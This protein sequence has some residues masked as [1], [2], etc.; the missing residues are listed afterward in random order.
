MVKQ[1]T[2]ES[3]TAKRRAF[4]K[5]NK[6]CSVDLSSNS[7]ENLPIQVANSFENQ[8]NGFLNTV[9]SG[10]QIHD[11]V[12]GQNSST[13]L[14]TFQSN[15]NLSSN[16]NICK[17]DHV[18]NFSYDDIALEN[19]QNL[20]K[21]QQQGLH[22]TDWKSISRGNLGDSRGSFSRFDLDQSG[23]I[24]KFQSDVLLNGERLANG[25][26]VDRK[27]DHLKLEIPQNPDATQNNRDIY[28]C[29]HHN[30]GIFYS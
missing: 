30:A 4:W 19:K 7:R 1:K 23:K 25:R 5:R 24:L 8:Q 3:Q 20:L 10:E 9:K 22:F 11:N 18:L 15:Y 29:P 17:S 27:I 13:S 26:A 16:Q 2:S 28:S 14:S 6:T 12:I 21:N